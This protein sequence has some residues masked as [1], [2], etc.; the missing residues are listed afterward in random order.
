LVTTKVSPAAGGQCLTEPGSLA[1]GA[2]QAVVDIDS[3]GLDTEA[4]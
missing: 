3:L 1:I 4:E 2:S